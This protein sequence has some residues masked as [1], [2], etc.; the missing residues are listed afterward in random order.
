[1]GHL[2]DLSLRDRG[3]VL[4]GA[5]LLIAFGALSLQRIHIDAVTEITP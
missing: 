5:A 1:M 4:L 3:L 2:I